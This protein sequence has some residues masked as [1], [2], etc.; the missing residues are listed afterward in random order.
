MLQRLNFPISKLISKNLKHFTKIEDML[1][2]LAF[3]ARFYEIFSMR[4]KVS[5]ALN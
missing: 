3:W 1:I 4:S 2:H 5:K